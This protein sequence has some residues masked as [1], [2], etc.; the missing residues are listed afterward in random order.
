MSK[1]NSHGKSAGNGSVHNSSVSAAGAAGPASRHHRRSRKNSHVGVGGGG[2]GGVERDPAADAVTGVAVDRS[3]VRDY[4]GTVA[5]HSQATTAA[6]R[7]H[8]LLCPSRVLYENTY[9]I[10]P[11]VH[12]YY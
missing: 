5:S 6:R 9:R 2:G 1:I 8:Q 12:V 4:A 3:T 11:Q 7:D 10:E